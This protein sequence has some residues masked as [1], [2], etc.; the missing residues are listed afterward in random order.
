[1]P[2]SPNWSNAIQTKIPTGI[3]YRNWKVNSKIH[4]GKEVQ[5]K[6]KYKVGE[7]TLPNFK[8]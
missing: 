8:T 6:K 2:I 1:M 5:L 3:F 7:L 4:K